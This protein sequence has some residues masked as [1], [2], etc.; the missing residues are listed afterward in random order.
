MSLF[1]K[2]LKYVFIILFF[3]LALYSCNFVINI[4]DENTIIPEEQPGEF[5]PSPI[6][7]TPV[8]TAERTD[9][10]WTEPTPDFTMEPTIE[11]TPD[12]TIEPTIVP[13]MDPT[14]EPT[15]DPTMEPTIVPTTD[16]TPTPTAD[17]TIEPTAEPTAE[18]TP[19][20]TGDPYEIIFDAGAAIG[21]FGGD[22]GSPRNVGNGQGVYIDNTIMITNFSFYFTSPFDY[23]VSPD[24]MGHEVTLRLQIR[25]FSGNI[26]THYD[27]IVPAPFSGG[28]VTWSGL[29][30]PAGIGE[31]LI[32]TTY[33]VDG[34]STMLTSGVAADS[35]AGYS[36]G[37]MYSIS[38]TTN[39]TM[40][41]WSNWGTHTWDSWFW[42]QGYV[43]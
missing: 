5:T 31:T 23:S 27:T 29:N 35:G 26:M 28:W 42:L 15:P 1:I 34:Y 43:Q 33:L 6:A 22:D 9:S 2:T 7:D 18:P 11:P 24:F 12:P 40:D 4:I 10:P 36:Q 3:I 8:P 20:N 37:Q 17:P 39:A 41:E 14:I 30:W 16:P 38:G 25:D 19:G 13:T 21:W 32:F